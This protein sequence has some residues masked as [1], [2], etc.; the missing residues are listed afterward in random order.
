MSFRAPVGRYDEMRCQRRE[1]GRSVN[2]KQLRDHS[3]TLGVRS[4]ASD[5]DINAAFRRLSKDAHPDAGGSLDQ[6]TELQ[7]AR[8]ALLNANETDPEP[9]VYL[10]TEGA[11]PGASSSSPV[12]REPVWLKGAVATLIIGAGS[13]A[14]G[15]AL[16]NQQI[17][18]IGVL[19]AVIVGIVVTTVQW[20]KRTRA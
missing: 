8:S 9:V 16:V 7:I 19:V 3:R 4:D 11:R 1:V 18:G 14:V 6:F 15:I 10:G 5:H 20:A 17:L 12:S 2:D 13:A